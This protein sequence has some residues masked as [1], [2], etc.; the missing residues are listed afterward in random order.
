M[1]IEYN[2]FQRENL[3]LN[4][5][6]GNLVT[7]SLQVLVELEFAWALALYVKHLCFVVAVWSKGGFT[8]KW[9]F[10]DTNLRTERW[11]KYWGL[12]SW[13]LGPN[14]GSQMFGLFYILI[15]IRKAFC[16]I[17]MWKTLCEVL[18][19]FQRLFLSHFPLVFLK[20]KLKQEEIHV[21]KGTVGG[22]F[23]GLLLVFLWAL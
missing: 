16:E 14:R 13:K 21:L 12:R 9:L 5:S 11:G 6:W 17:L 1:K 18:T 3:V 19:I 22:S 8:C 7:F 23:C 20:A 15:W 10:T 4:Q 2:G